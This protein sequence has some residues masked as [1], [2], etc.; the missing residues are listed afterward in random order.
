MK[1]VAIPVTNGFMSEY[2]E[3]CDYYKI[4]NVEG[5]NIRSKKIE[6]PSKEN[7][8]KL[9]EWAAK[10]GIT[11]IVTFKVDKR[12]ITLFSLFRINL[13]VGIP[14]NIPVHKIISDFI[15]GK[16]TSDEEIISE[17][18]SENEKNR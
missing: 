3:Q 12:I 7:I 5:R 14:V 17:I 16:L 8:S 1:K 9:P 11:D 10:E 4:F 2:F 18:M 13:Y 6:N 15:G